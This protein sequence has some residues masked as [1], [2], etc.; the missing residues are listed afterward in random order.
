MFTLDPATEDEP[1]SGTIASATP[2]SS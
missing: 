1:G 2:A